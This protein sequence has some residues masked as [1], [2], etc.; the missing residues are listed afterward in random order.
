MFCHT[1]FHIYHGFTSWRDTVVDTS[2]NPPTTTPEKDQTKILDVSKID[3]DQDWPRSTYRLTQ[4]NQDWLGSSE[5]ERDRPR[6]TSRDQSILV[7]PGQLLLWG[8]DLP[9]HFF[10]ILQMLA[11]F[12]MQT[13]TVS[14]LILLN[15]LKSKKLMERGAFV[16]HGWSYISSHL[17]VH[18]IVSTCTGSSWDL[19][20]AHQRKYLGI[21]TTLPKATS[22]DVRYCTI[23]CNGSSINSSLYVESIIPKVTTF[24]HCYW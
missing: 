5:I 19:S 1:V 7:D 20:C 4:I 18:A 22:S 16:A 17:R 6:W 13:S 24:Q 11:R 9:K 15:Q 3:I 14:F 21:L 8:G 2:S 10:R 12:R 23:F